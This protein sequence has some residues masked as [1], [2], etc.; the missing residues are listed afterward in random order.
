MSV[1]FW[2]KPKKVRSK[3][4]WEEHYGFDGGP[5]G[6]Y[7]PNMSEEDEAKWKA[8]ITGTKLGYPQ[9]EI[10]RNG[11]VVIVNL[12]KGYNYK[13]YRSENPEYTQYKTFKE[14]VD[15][16]VKKY[17]TLGRSYFKKEER[18]ANLEEQKYPTR[19]VNVHISTA[20]P[21]QWDFKELAEF[22]QAIEE[23]K[24]ALL[25]LESK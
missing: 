13:Q 20:G 2:G 15:A 17:P 11:V 3:E 5:K 18:K 23:A 21:I 24:E 16:M 9:V 6:G 25:K 14:Y 4:E 8:K 22:Q 7:M 19:G 10:R 12:G 1:L